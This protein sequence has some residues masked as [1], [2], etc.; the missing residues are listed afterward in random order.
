[1]SARVQRDA[2]SGPMLSVRLCFVGQRETL[3]HRMACI[4]V[5]LARLWLQMNGGV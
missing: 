4:A 1:M 3:G 5:A 2:L